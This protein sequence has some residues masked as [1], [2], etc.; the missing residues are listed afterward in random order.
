M[1]GVTLV[2]G[3]SHLS[4]PVAASVITLPCGHLDFP[5]A[6]SICCQGPLPA[7][8]LLTLGHQHSERQHILDTVITRPAYRKAKSGRTRLNAE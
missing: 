8:L 5:K 2:A 3:T 7:H 6:T 4:L 1:I